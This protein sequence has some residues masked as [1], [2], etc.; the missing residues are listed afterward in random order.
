MNMD[1]FQYMLA[2]LED[3]TSNALRSVCF[4]HGADVTCTELARVEALARKNKSTWERIVQHDETPTMIQ[5]LGAKERM[6]A[7]FLPMFEP[8]KGFTGFNLNLGCSSPNV[9][10]MGQGCAL[11][12]RISK[13]QKIVKLIQD[14]GYP[15]SIKMRLGLNLFEKK[16]KVYLNLINKVDADFFIVH[17]RHAAETLKNPADK[18]IYPACVA[19]EKNIIAN[20][21][22]T[23]PEQ[24]EH[25]KSIGLKGVMI[26]RAAIEDPQIFAKMKGMPSTGT[27]VI[28]KEFVEFTK[29]F[30]EHPK[31]SKNVLKWMK[32]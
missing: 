3:V 7:K 10:Q 28:K 13:T 11:V 24:V 32:Q 31:Y 25:L 5:L 23:T 14:A 19:T 26:G 6:F 27:D 4:K 22:I 15:V 30:H 20:G 8:K 17:A 1:K 12:K 9:I 21:D 29:R 16:K 2:P 18:S